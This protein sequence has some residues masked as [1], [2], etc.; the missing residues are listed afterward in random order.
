MSSTS[1]RAGVALKRKKASPPAARSTVPAPAKVPH[2]PFTPTVNNN[3][4]NGP[5]NS[6]RIPHRPFTPSA[7]GGGSLASS[8]PSSL[9]PPPPPPAWHAS[10]DA[11]TSFAHT[12]GA[13]SLSNIRRSPVKE[14]SAAFVQARTAYANLVRKG[15]YLSK[16]PD[17]LLSTATAAVPGHQ[18]RWA[19]RRPDLSEPAP[20][21]AAALE[22]R[23]GMIKQAER[24]SL[25]QHDEAVRG[26][27]RRGAGSPPD[28]RAERRPLIQSF[29]VNHL[30]RPE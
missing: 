18:P 20:E 9:P 28:F 27:C 13:T 1:S 12:G 23:R 7:V 10:L 29:P 8:Q 5:S 6:N 26:T 11:S 3:S 25:E 15:A 14:E 17:W 4:Q 24:Q 30:Y 2:R 22:R 16:T 19:F 21:D